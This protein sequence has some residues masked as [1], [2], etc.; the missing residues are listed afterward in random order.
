MEFQLGLVKHKNKE[1]KRSFL[2]NQ[3]TPIHLL[4]LLLLLVGVHLYC[5]LLN[6][7]DKD[8]A[9]LKDRKAHLCSEGEQEG[10][11]GTGH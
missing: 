8:A 11:K 9:L 7:K 3:A 2:V 5:C 10:L 4:L 1:I 6:V